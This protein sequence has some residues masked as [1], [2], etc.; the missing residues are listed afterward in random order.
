MSSVG[1]I[2]DGPAAGAISLQS[3]ARA[4]FARMETPPS[5]AFREAV[6]WAIWRWKA[7]GAWSQIKGLWILA[8]DTAQAARLSAIGD[9]PRDATVVGTSPTFTALKGY[10]G[11][12]SGKAIRFPITSAILASD[13]VYAFA[14]LLAQGQSDMTDPENPVAYYGPMIQNDAGG[15]SSCP[16]NWF[17]SLDGAPFPQAWIYP[18]LMSRT[19]MVGGR[20]GGVAISA[21][22]V[23]AS[24]GVTARGSNYTTHAHALTALQRLSAY[25]F[26]DAAASEATCRRFT[27]ILAAMLDQLGA[28]D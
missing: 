5:A 8:A 7:I 16:G 12:A 4:Y 27:A 22:A 2:G 10:S 14:A 15:T 11:F 24:S 26:L 28:L 9:T 18:T 25:G 19:H 21:G 13:S 23:A 1:Y 3:E 6:N 20:R 17:Y